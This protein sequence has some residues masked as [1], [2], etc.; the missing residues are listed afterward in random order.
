MRLLHEQFEHTVEGFFY[1]GAYQTN[2]RRRTFPSWRPKR[3]SLRFHLMII[4][5]RFRSDWK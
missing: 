2:F 1:K 4:K 5:D 3:R